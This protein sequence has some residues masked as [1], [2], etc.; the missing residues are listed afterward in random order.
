MHWI[1]ERGPASH[2][3]YKALLLPSA[4]EKS[5]DNNNN[6]QVTVELI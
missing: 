2:D 3:H 5:S 6:D 4:I 1:A